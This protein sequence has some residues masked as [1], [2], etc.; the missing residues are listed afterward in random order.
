[1][2][3][4]CKYLPFSGIEN[5][6]KQVAQFVNYLKPDFLDEIAEVCE[7]GD[8]DAESESA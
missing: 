1:M 2:R 4:M 6:L 7:S 8:D 3:E 5:R